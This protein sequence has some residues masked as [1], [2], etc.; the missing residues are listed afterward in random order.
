[1]T[2]FKFFLIICNF[3]SKKFICILNLSICF[4]L[5]FWTWFMFISLIYFG[6]LGFSFESFDATGI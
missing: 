4:I 6:I 1:M 3:F 5:N 2:L